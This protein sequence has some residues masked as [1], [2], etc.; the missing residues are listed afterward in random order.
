V[1]DFLREEGIDLRKRIEF[2]TYSTIAVGGI[3]RDERAATN[4]EGLYTAGDEW[5]NGISAAS[6]FGWIGGENAALHAQ[7]APDAASAGEQGIVDAM[8]RR[9][10]R[11]MRSD[12]GAFYEWQD[13]NYALHQTMRDYAGIVR[14]GP[15]L[16][17]G[18]SHLARLKAKVRAC[19]R[20]RFELIRCLKP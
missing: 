10:A 16:Q 15:M 17:A 18:L 1:V 14:S 3:F 2:M 13:A 19:V 12:S 5:G 8:R 6:V 4:L 20:N 7:R 9:M 11:F